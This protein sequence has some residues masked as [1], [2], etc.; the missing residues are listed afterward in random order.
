MASS[1]GPT[2]NWSLPWSAEEDARGGAL[3]RLF[4]VIVEPH[5]LGGGGRQRRGRWTGMWLRGL[6]LE[7]APPRVAGHTYDGDEV[8]MET[9]KAEA[10]EGDRRLKAG[11]SVY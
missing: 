4:F 7:E 5:S 3:G 9:R 6:L 10:G 11:R 2:K 1:P 8:A